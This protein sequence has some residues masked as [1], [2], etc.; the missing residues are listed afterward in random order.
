GLE[1]LNARS[2]TELVQNLLGGMEVEAQLG[3]EIIKK[4]GGNPF[5]LEEIVRELLERGDLARED[6]RFKCILPLD[7]C[8][9]PTTVQGVLAARIDRLTDDLKRTI[10]VA[11]VVGRDFSYRLMEAVME[12]GD[13]LRAHL[14]S[15][16]ALDFVSEKTLYPEPEYSFRH[17]LAQEVAYESLLKPR[18]QEIHRR[19]ARA[20]E[21]LYAD[22]L[23]Q[24]AEILAHHWEL[25]DTPERSIS[26][27][28][29]AG[30]KSNRCMAASAA[31][32]FFTRAL[33][34]IER[35]GKPSDPGLLLR[36]RAGRADPLHTMGKIEESFAD[37]QEA[38]RLA[39]EMGDDQ[40]A[41]N[42]L[43]GIP[44][45]IYNTRLNS[46]VPQFCEEGLQLARALGNKGAEARSITNYAFWHHVWHGYDDFE[47][48][49]RALALAQESGQ[50]PAIFVV[51]LMLALFERS[52]GD[53]RRSLEYSEG[54][55]EMLQS[56]FNIFAASVLSFV[57]G[58]ALIEAGR[59]EEAIRF[60]SDWKEIM[61]R[62]AIYINLG[63]C[64]NSL[65]WAYAE[66]Y[67]LER[68]LQCNQQASHVIAILRKSPSHF[69]QALEMQTM[70]EVN[71]MENAFDVGKV[72]E[73]WQHLASFEQT[74]AHPDYGL[75][76]DRWTLRMMDLKGRVLLR[77]GDLDEA[78]R[79]ARRCL[80][81]ATQRRY[82]KYVGKSERLLGQIATEKGGYDLAKV[83]L[84]MAL[85]E[86]EEVGNP[87][88]LWITWTALARLYQ[89]MGDVDKEG[90][91]WQAAAAVVRSTADGL[92]DGELRSRFLDAAPIR[93]IIEKANTPAGP[94]A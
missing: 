80:D 90:K 56:A 14:A 62:N 32:D 68:A 38:I 51:R 37:Y 93:E 82:K 22:R 26:Y 35:T 41:L 28:V 7:H 85:S 88:Q 30:E 21:E 76:R 36:I 55:I 89:R 77:R 63:R 23:E 64:C 17:A 61:E 65:G 45:L 29:R 79:I 40:T 53:P 27:L 42:C 91:Q 24:Q 11:S 48:L 44:T 13:E 16:V 87:K 1:E 70:T 2:S 67:D 31:V 81:L 43:T 3:Q 5:F 83:K 86:L 71:L 74:S 33:G 4:T 78:E 60:L 15:L 47:V 12:L 94:S 54:L 19:V 18:R 73:A 58:W 25:S 46:Q 34:Q 75:R 6:S 39:K 72:D 57:R 52:R 9:I 20:I 10:Q 66:L 59:Y 84:G 92:T 69:L 8:R 49:H 50:S